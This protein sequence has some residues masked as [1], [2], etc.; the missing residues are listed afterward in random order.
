MAGRD[1]EEEP[2]EP[3]CL[4]GGGDLFVFTGNDT[5]EG[6]ERETDLEIVNIQSL[7]KTRRERVSESA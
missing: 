1:S 4:G 7:K 5:I 6:P 3:G 2:E